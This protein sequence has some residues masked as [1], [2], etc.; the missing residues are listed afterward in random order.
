MKEHL[1][2]GIDLG[3]S[4]IR[5]AVGQ[6]AAGADKRETL[7]IIGAIEVASQGISK[8]SINSLE[9]VISAISAALEQVER[10][11]GLPVSEVYVSIGGMHMMVQPAKGVVGVSRPDGE[12]REEDIQRALES[13]RALVNPANYDVIHILPKKFVVDGQTGVKDPVGMQGIRLEVEAHIIQGFSAHVRN[14][15]KA[16][17]RTGLD[18]R[19]LVFS[20]L[21]AAEAVTTSRQ[22]E[23]GTVVVNIGASTTSMAVYEEGD[24][25]H[26]AVFPI[27]ADHITSD[28][29]IGLRTSLEVAE[30]I[31]RNYASAYA[32]PMSRFEEINLRELGADHAEMVSRR[33]VSD[34]A[35][36]RAEE[37]FE[38]VEKELKKIERSG[39]LPAGVI[40]TGGGIKLSGMSDIARQVLRLPVSVGAATNTQTPLVELGQDP[41]FATSIGLVLW[42]YASER[43]GY[44]G[45]TKGGS[46]GA[47]GGQMMKKLGEPLK[48]IFKSFIP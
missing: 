35:Q 21:A 27:G 44:E 23:V 10:Q 5:L 48:K 20:P 32:E 38:R 39:M 29:A 30:H 24:L 31:K 15:T 11:V 40:L 7:S 28:I 3:S 41:A 46:Y 18:V 43:E 45:N 34:I 4:A 19:E 42:G 22:R 47:K 16:V 13:A 33:F 25:L 14:L 36:A 6:I 1:I 8:G 2:V 9:D 26:A 37:I 17:F 12:I